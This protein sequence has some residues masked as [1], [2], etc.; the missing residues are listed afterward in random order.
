M[1][2]TLFGGRIPEYQLI[3]LLNNEQPGIWKLITD[4]TMVNSM[5]LTGMMILLSGM[6][7]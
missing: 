7:I 6:C 5:A 3:N 4:I 1:N 2:Q